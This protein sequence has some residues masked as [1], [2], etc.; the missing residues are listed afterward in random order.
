MAT[1]WGYLNVVTV[2]PVLFL[3][4]MSLFMQYPATQLLVLQKVCLAKHNS[5]ALCANLS[6]DTEE[7]NEVQ[8]VAA[9]WNLYMTVAINLP[10]AL[11]SGIYGAISDRVSRRSI[12]ALPSIGIILGSVSFLL[13]SHF[14]HA[15]VGY[16]LISALT[17]GVFGNVGAS[18]I[19]LMSYMCDITETS[20]RTKRL[21]IM[22]SMTFIGG[23]I[24]MMSAGAIL[25]HYGFE[26]VYLIIIALNSS[27]I[28]Y[29]MLRLEEPL[30]KQVIPEGISR[31]VS[32]N[33]I[34]WVCRHV[35]DSLHRTLNVYFIK[36]E[37]KKRRY[38]W[39]FQLLGILGIIAFAG[40]L[41]LFILYTKH[42]PLSWSASTIG[43]YLSVRTLLKGA[44]LAVG[45]PVLFRYF[46]DRSVRFDLVLAMLGLV[47]IAASMIL[48]AF[49]HTMFMMALVA[50]IGCLSGYPGAI[51]GSIKSKLVQPTEFVTCGLTW[52][53]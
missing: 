16:L 33:K 8:S 28:L 13:Q 31:N 47:S 21:G 40:E 51:M 46:S 22:E 37:G 10:G 5:T 53:T 50:C 3:F 27:I 29:I 30:K 18:Y 45:L 35:Y 11:M 32:P 36:R 24:G 39:L 25:Q 1:F 17:I 49:S 26:A 9:H 41:D 48:V 20:S 2:E 43:V 4:T 44:P 19:A 34:T 14:I 7:E 42:S 23:P 38:L 6:E 15:H 52:Q 12:M